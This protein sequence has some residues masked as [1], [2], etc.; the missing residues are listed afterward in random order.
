MRGNANEEKRLVRR[1]ASRPAHRC[2]RYPRL[3][4]TR[5]RCAAIRTW[6]ES[7][8]KEFRFTWIGQAKEGDGDR[9][10]DPALGPISG[11]SVEASRET[12]QVGRHAAARGATC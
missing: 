2:A 11:K 1:P 8:K 10:H 6:S 9:S 7:R 4:S 12:R 5:P 3:T